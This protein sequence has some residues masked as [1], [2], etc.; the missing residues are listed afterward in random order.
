MDE[1]GGDAAHR[2]Q[3]V[4]IASRGFIAVTYAVEASG[5]RVTVDVRQ[6]QAGYSEVGVLNEQS[7]AFDDLAS[8]AGP[9]L[10]GDAFGN[11]VPVTGG[12]ARL[13]SGALGVEW[14]VSALPGAS[15]HGGR[16]HVP[17]DFD[18]AGLDY[19][20]PAPFTGVSYRINVQEAR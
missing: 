12:W 18:W 16:E 10:I 15:L 17:P 5:V 8:A 7:A 2:Y 6:L 9:T 3:F 13:R 14:S 11:W 4:P 19:I 20:F 1:I